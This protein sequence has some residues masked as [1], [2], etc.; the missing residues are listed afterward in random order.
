[1]LISDVIKVL[2]NTTLKEFPWGC[3]VR[4]TVNVFAVDPYRLTDASTG[5][6]VL[7]ALESLPE[8][9]RDLVMRASIDPNRRC[10]TTPIGGGMVVEH[11]DRKPEPAPDSDEVTADTAALRHA[12]MNPQFMGVFFMVFLG[13]CMAGYMIS[14]LSVHNG[15]DWSAVFSAF[16]K[17]FGF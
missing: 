1:M 9:N 13:L 4:D 8:E 14:T 16:W 15:I 12:L 3:A 5:V 7:A 10:T 17:V 2:G 11:V 6:D